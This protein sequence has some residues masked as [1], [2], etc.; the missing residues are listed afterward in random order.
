MEII[1]EIKNNK[2]GKALINFLKQLPF[3]K[4]RNSNKLKSGQE[5]EKI[6]GLWKD[7]DITKEKIRENA[8]RI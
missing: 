8:W 7:R 6:F 5:F 4:I 3:V 1:L 2:E